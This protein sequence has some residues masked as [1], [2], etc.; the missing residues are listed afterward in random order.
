M[1]EKTRA[2]AQAPTPPCSGFIILSKLPN[3]H[4]FWS[5]G[6]HNVSDDVLCACRPHLCWMDSESSELRP[7]SLRWP[8][9]QAPVWREDP[10]RTTAHT[11]VPS[12]RWPARSGRA[13]RKVLLC[14][15]SHGTCTLLDKGTHPEG[16]PFPIFYKDTECLE[17]S[18][19]PQ[20]F[21]SP[22]RITWCKKIRQKA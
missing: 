5:L 14:S 4:G 3:V 22:S 13:E 9:W 7:V 17:G 2:L 19:D 15:P 10:R 8:F 11:S 21:K 12:T 6:Q 16:V 1:P 20:D 18:W